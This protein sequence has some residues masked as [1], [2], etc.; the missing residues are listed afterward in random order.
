MQ[1]LWKGANLC[2]A[3]P[4]P[5]S[6]HAACRIAHTFAVSQSTAAFIGSSI[7]NSKKTRLLSRP[8]VS[9]GQYTTTSQV[10]ERAAAV[11]F[12]DAITRLHAFWS[13]Q[14]CAGWLPHNTE[15]RIVTWMAI[16]QMYN[17]PREPI[18]PSRPLAGGCRHHEPCHFS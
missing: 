3:A 4:V 11:T 2:R 18:G 15:V 17:C 5:G 12:Q 9:L 14:G 10:P 16:M 6:L 13:E 8:G 1:W 7:R